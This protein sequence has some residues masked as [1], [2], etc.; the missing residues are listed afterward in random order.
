VRLFVVHL[1]GR[2]CHIL[3]AGTIG[4]WVMGVCV[5]EVVLWVAGVA[6]Q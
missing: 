2:Q 5:C 3:G 4:F 6:E 1:L